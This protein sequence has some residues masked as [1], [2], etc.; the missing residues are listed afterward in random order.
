MDITTA[1]RNR[2]LGLC[3]ERDITVNKLAT[4]CGI[5][6][7]TLVNVMNGRNGLSVLTLK[8][9]CDGLEITLAEFFNTEIFNNLEQEIR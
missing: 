4:I 5:P 7:G 8:K 1:V 2:I 3:Q 6:P 9:I